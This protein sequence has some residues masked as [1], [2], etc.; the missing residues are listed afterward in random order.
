M[1]PREKIQA[2]G[3]TALTDEELVRLL[4]GAG[5]AAVPLT[6]T[7]AS[8]EAAYP[9]LVG[10]EEAPLAALMT[11][12]GLGL[13]KAATLPGAIEFGRRVLRRRT[14]RQGTAVDSAEVGREM[15]AR[16]AGETEEHLLAVY[17]DVGNRVIAERDVARGG[18]DHAVADPRVVF[19]AALLVNAAGVILIHNHPSGG[20]APSEAD[21]ATTRRFASA[22]LTLGVMLL[23]HLVIGEHDYYSFRADHNI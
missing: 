23:D 2:Y 20:A 11:L 12:P 13:A 18:L 6:A 19:R 15:V 4:L 21:K 7:V 14:L 17:L 10:L 16:L 22:G 1:Q 3:A 8:L 5:S 9:R